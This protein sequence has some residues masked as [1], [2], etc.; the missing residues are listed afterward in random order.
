MSVKS[1][2]L[3]LVLAQFVV[4][5]V[6][7]I[8]ECCL[9]QIY[10]TSANKDGPAKGERDWVHKDVVPSAVFTEATRHAARASNRLRATGSG[11]G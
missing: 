11:G 1:S 5:L 2:I 4:I 9:R 3:V 10:A 8:L 6:F 7:G